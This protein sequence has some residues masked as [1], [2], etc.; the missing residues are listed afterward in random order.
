MLCCNPVRL[1]L[2]CAPPPR[3]LSVS[4]NMS[5]ATITSWPT[6]WGKITDG[7]LVC[8]CLLLSIFSSP[9][10]YPMALLLSRICSLP[11][12]CCFGPFVQA[13]L[14]YWCVHCVPVSSK[15]SLIGADAIADKKLDAH[16]DHT[17]SLILHKKTLMLEE[18]CLIWLI[19]IAEASC[20]LQLNAFLHKGQVWT[21][22]T[23]T[24]CFPVHI[25]ACGYC[26]KV[27]LK[28]CAPI[29]K[30]LLRKILGLQD[31][32]LEFITMETIEVWHRLL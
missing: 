5:K 32:G 6:W 28:K 4:G 17:Y 13:V 20:Y 25:W 8:V 10:R 14:W 18:I 26:I 30:E 12:L 2:S 16:F 29:F 1:T 19:Q 21:A 9:L 11:P 3:R 24:G 27:D 15:D 7:F 22:G 31:Q 23:I